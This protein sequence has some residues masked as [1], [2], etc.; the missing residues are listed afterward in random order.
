ML[1]LG[2]GMANTFLHARGVGVGASLAEKDMAEAAREILKKAEAA[3]CEVLLPVDGIVAK[4]FKAGAPSRDVPVDQVPPDMMI[5]DVGP[6]SVEM[7][8]LK[9]QGAKTVLWNGPLGAFENKPFDAGRSE[10]HTSEL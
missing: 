4:E 7:L 1:V 8:T 10:E 9:I 2:G 5:L 3:G 6:K